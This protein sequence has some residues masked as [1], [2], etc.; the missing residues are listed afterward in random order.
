MLIKTA[1]TQQSSRLLSVAAD[2]IVG[3][4]ANNMSRVVHRDE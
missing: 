2:F 4:Q 3:R 1:I